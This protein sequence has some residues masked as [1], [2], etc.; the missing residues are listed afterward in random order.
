M[1]PA[2]GGIVIEHLVKRF[3]ERA[4]VDDLNLHIQPGE[5]FVLV[6][7]SGCGKTTTLRLLAGLE[8]VSDGRIYFGERLVNDIRP[9]DRNV[10][11]VFQDYAIFPHLTVFENIAYGLRARHA[12]R[13][14]IRE[15]VANAARLFR[16]EHLLGRKPRQLS[17]GERQ[18]VALARALVRDA[19]LYLYDEPLA[20]LDA[21]LR[22]QA[23]EDILTL[24][25]QKGQPAVYVTHDQ[26]EAMALGDRIA[27]MRDGKLQQV[28]SGLDLYERPCNQFVAFFIGSPGINLFEVE[29]HP[30]QD[31]GLRLVHPAFRLPVPEEFQAR[32]APYTGRRLNLG[33][34]PEHLQPPKRADFAV[35]EDSTIRGLVNVIEPT[36]SGCTVYLSTLEPTPRD[37]VATLK[38]RLPG[39][40]LGREVPLA[41][42]LR[43]IHLFDP[44]DGQALLHGPLATDD[45]PIRVTVSPSGEPANGPAEQPTSE[46]E[47]SE[48]STQREE[49]A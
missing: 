15:R 17:G 24:H 47:T 40:Y 46:R 29:V 38:A 33:I 39:S 32:V 12:P 10:A 27:V 22:H 6:G 43:K 18:R 5:L 3:G 20:N 9:R 19:A 35:S 16:I 31:G 30:D 48:A 28:G 42:N 1:G 4:V 25:R 2:S 8:P 44:E 34:R 41:V 14:L 45:R 21:Q 26:A 7:P 11:L 36:V 49:Q 23:R 37:F 13:N